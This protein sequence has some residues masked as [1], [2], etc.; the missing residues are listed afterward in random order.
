MLSSLLVNQLSLRDSST[1]FPPEEGIEAE[2]LNVSVGVLE[3]QG[4]VITYRTEDG[5]FWG[6][7]LGAS[8]PSSVAATAAATS[9]PS[10]VKALTSLGFGWI[11]AWGQTC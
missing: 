1:K 7:C 11:R 9:G 3:C 2:V 6:R 8:V 5:R 10:H 4:E